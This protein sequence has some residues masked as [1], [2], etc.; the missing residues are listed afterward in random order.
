MPC[1]SAWG[2]PSFLLLF[3][4]LSFIYHT[5]SFNS[6][7]QQ[8]CI[9]G[10]VKMAGGE[11]ATEANLSPANNAASMGGPDGGNGNISQVVSWTARFV[12]RISE[13]T[14]SMNVGGTCI[15]SRLPSITIRLPRAL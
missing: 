12:D 13:V 6:F 10:A 1:V 9:D 11:N 3:F 15:L 5:H 4:N 2:A 14:D 7:T 8:L